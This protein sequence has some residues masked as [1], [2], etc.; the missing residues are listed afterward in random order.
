MAATKRNFKDLEE[1]IPGYINNITNNYEFP[2]L[3]KETVSGK[4]R[5]WQIKIRIIKSDSVRRDITSKQNWNEMEENSVCIKPGY[6][7]GDAK[8]LSGES[9]EM[10]SESGLLSGTL[11]KSP[12]T[13]VTGKNI[14]R[15]NE[16]NPFQQALIT[17]RGTWLLKIDQGSRDILSKTGPKKLVVENSALKFYPMLANNYEKVKDIEY[18]VYIQPKLDGIRC[19]I[20]LDFKNKKVV[21]YSRQLKEFPSNNVCDN[22]RMCLFDI[23][24]KNY[25]GESVYLDGELFKKGIS[26]QK[27]NS[28]SRTTEDSEDFLEFHNYD[29]FYPSYGGKTPDPDFSER[30]TLLKKIHSGLSK[31]NS[32]FIK[33]VPTL[34]VKN[35][36]ENDILYKKNLKDSYEGS[37]IRSL[38]GLYL[39][40]SVKKSEQ[41][42]S[43]DLLKR[44]EI[45]DEEFEVVGYTQGIKGKSVGC[46]IW[47]CE[48]RNGEFNVVPNQTYAERAEIFKELGKKFDTKYRGRMLTVEFR[49]LSDKGIPT[50]AKAI[51]FRDNK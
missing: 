10:W 15:K 8:F 1:N 20:F 37:M 22:I 42:R 17:A 44:K 26:L 33:F 21:M 6:I 38:G 32:K 27:I 18:P 47:I 11:S 50:L 4:I 43:N 46:V 19:I 40:S 13:Y 35:E 36:K 7:T 25:N 48:S 51:G 14:G 30:T 24:L 28:I 39:K 34:L 49:G 29:M 3:Y 9:V 2:I 45:F 16:T 23:L 5:Q 31:E 41:L 12:A